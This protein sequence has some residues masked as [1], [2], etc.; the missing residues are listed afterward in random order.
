MTARAKAP[1]V[2]PMGCPACKRL[3]IPGTACA[4]C[5]EAAH[6]AAVRRADRELRFGR[7]AATVRMAVASDA[8]AAWVGANLLIDELGVLLMHV[9]FEVPRA[10]GRS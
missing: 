7:D 6:G 3:G 4:V 2:A 8:R 1:T 5:V 9:G 10:Q